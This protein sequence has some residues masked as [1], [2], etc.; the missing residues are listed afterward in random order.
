[1][2]IA[3]ISVDTAIPFRL[4]L[5]VEERAEVRA[6]AE[7]LRRVAPGLVD[8]E[9]WVAE[10]RR[11]SCRLPL[12]LL[13]RIREYRSDAGPDGMLCLAGLP[14]DE[15]LLPQ[16]PSVPDSVERV[17]TV[18]AA[19]AMLVGQQLGEVIAY[20]DEKFGALVQN[21]V[22]VP[23]LA[24]SQSNGGSV[25]LEFH[26]E[27]AFHPHR[28]HYVGLLCLR[29]DHEGTAGTQVCSVRRVLGRIDE[30]DRKILEAPRFVTEAPPSFRSA[31][32][33]EPH[34]VLGGSSEDPDL[35]VD[36]NATSALDEEAGHALT[37]L[38]DTMLDTSESLVLAPGELVFLDNRLVVHG[39]TDFVPRYD[40]R[41]RW[42]HRIFVHLDNRLSRPHRADNGPVLV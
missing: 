23:S 37:R 17:A 22:P 31:E 25:P 19:V 29:S 12:R 33:T 41:D 38:R 39:R 16:T 34:P 15:D 8:E 40:G 26:I 28:P 30:A 14:V 9:A 24:A 1:M 13:E 36:F 20:R 5:T 42:L 32:R 18:P 4:D 7:E 6:L 21:V 27:N 3:D 35:R 10:A 11:L 2:S